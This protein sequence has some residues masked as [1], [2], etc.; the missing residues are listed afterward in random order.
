MADPRV[1]GLV[2][3]GV[4]I[5]LLFVGLALRNHDP[6]ARFG[7]YVG[8]LLIILGAACAVSGVWALSGGLN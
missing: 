8:G 4:G 2:V 6:S 5:T 1:A 7:D 3:A